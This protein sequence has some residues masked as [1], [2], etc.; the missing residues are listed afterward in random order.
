MVLQPV[1]ETESIEQWPGPAPWSPVLAAETNVESLAGMRTF[2]PDRDYP[3]KI[4]EELD[5]LGKAQDAASDEGQEKKRK[6]RGRRG[7]KH[8]SHQSGSRGNDKDKRGRGG[9]GGSSSHGIT[10]I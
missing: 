8:R 3:D 5:E 9:G 6:R 7:R 10:A 4:E 2:P 1:N